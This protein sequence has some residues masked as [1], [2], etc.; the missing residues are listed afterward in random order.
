LA[1]NLEK[2]LRIAADC[3][4]LMLPEHIADQVADIQGSLV[5]VH[6]VYSKNAAALVQFKDDGLPAD[7]SLLLISFIDQPLTDQA[8]DNTGDRAFV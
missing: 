3:L 1:A 4:H 5:K 2:I 7:G 8:G 6:F